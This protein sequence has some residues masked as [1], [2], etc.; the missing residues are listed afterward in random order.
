M[1]LSPEKYSYLICLSA[2]RFEHAHTYANTSR[3][4]TREHNHDTIET[5]LLCRAA[6]NASSYLRSDI[7]L[8]SS[9]VGSKGASACCTNISLKFGKKLNASH[10]LCNCWRYVK[11]SQEWVSESASKYY[12]TKTAYHLMQPSQWSITQLRSQGIHCFWVCTGSSN[13]Q[14]LAVTISQLSAQCFRDRWCWIN[15][16]LQ[17]QVGISKIEIKIMV[18]YLVWNSSSKYKGNLRTMSIMS[19]SFVVSPELQLYKTE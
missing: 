7:N 12:K 6:V 5:S 10:T 1:G 19:T 8:D 16:I 13:S 11:N 9:L 15:C 2:Y 18:V 17:I 4:L 14:D 3:E